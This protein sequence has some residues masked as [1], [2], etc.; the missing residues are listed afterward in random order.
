MHPANPDK[1]EGL[2]PLGNAPPLWRKPNFL[3]YWL[4]PVLWGLAVLVMAG[5]LGSDKNTYGL[6]RFLLSWF[7]DLTKAQLDLINLWVRKT[8]HVLAY[9]LMYWLYFRAFRKQAHYRP[10]HA[11]LWSLGFCLLFSSMDEGRQLLY[12]TRGASIRDVMLDM[13]GAGLAALIVAAVRPPGAKTAPM[14]AI[15]GRQTSGPE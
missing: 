5:D 12:P 4:P 14:S 13:S 11:S 9:A 3:Y 6:L 10:W 7:W 2:E 15:D 1:G 8:G